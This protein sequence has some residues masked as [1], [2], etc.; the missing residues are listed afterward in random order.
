MV[1]QLGGSAL[2]VPDSL[3]R[4]RSWNRNYH[5]CQTSA[6]SSRARAKRGGAHAPC[7]LDEVQQPVQHRV[8]LFRQ[9]APTVTGARPCSR[10]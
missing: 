10:R 1:T 2:A 8:G 5:S 4:V 9:D 3:V 7:T 6:P